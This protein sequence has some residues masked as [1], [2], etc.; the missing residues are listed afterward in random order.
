[1]KMAGIVASTLRRRTFR[2][3]IPLD[4]RYQA[5]DPV[6]ISLSPTGSHPPSRSQ[7][8]IKGEP[9][10]EHGRLPKAAKLFSMD[11]WPNCMNPMEQNLT[12]VEFDSFE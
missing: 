3:K 12:L 7:S 11:F 6:H 10:A 2:Q 8:F 1:M 4:V 5:I 9:S